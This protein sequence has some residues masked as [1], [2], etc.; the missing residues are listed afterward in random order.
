MQGYKFRKEKEE[1]T[2]KVAEK[3]KLNQAMKQITNVDDTKE[4]SDWEDDDGID[5][6]QGLNDIEKNEKEAIVLYK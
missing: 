5:M 3:L 6:E 4:E 2:K 1:K